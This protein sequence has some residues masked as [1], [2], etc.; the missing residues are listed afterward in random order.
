MPKVGVRDLQRDASGVIARVMR[1]GRPTIVTKYNEPVAALVAIDPGEL[2]D[3]VLANAPEF[4]QSMREAD[5]A[6]AEGR[7]QGAAEVFAEL[8]AEPEPADG[9][10]AEPELPSIT[11]RER[12]VLVLLAEGRTNRQIAERLRINEATVRRHIR[13]VLAKLGTGEQT[14]VR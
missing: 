3:F 5:L 10:T 8:D 12:E 14:P 6:L 4:V 2:E 13:H 9:W 1:T 11:P 7:T